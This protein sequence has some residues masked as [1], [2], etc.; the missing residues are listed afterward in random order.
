MAG[1]FA[2]H[3]GLDLTATNKTV[4]NEWNKND[5]FHKSITER[6]GCPQFVFSKVLLLLTAI[7]AFIMFWHAR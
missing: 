2:E 6:E 3:K 1:K 5:V 7:L 4:L